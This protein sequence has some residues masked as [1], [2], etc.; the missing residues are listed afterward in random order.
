MTRALLRNLRRGMRVAFFLRVE[1]KVWEA[2][3][4]HVALIA[5][6][7]TVMSI[8]LYWTYYGTS[9]VFDWRGLYGPWLDVV[10]FL[11]VSWL[12]VRYAPRA[13]G[14]L[15][16]AVALFAAAF[17]TG[18]VYVA[19][20]HV[21][22][23]L[24]EWPAVERVAWLGLY[25]GWPVWFGMLAVVLLR[26]TARIAYRHMPVVIAPLVLWM[27]FTY[28]VSAP[29]YWYMPPPDTR[30]TAPPQASPVSEEILYLQP[31]L[32]RQ[33]L[34][35]IADQRA[36]IDDLY[37]IG[38]APHGEEDVFM[39]ESEVIRALMDQRFDTR[40]RSLLLINNNKT[41]LQ[42]PLATATNLQAALKTVGQL[43]DPDDDVL[44][45]YLTS[46][47]TR[48][49]RLS[50]EYWPLRLEQVTPLKLKTW[51]NEAKIRWRIIVVSACF[52]GGYVEP[53][54]GPTTLIM[55]ASD[56]THTS[57][58]CGT[59]SDFTYF[60][61]ALF[62]EQLRETFSFEQAFERAVPVIKE[63]EQVED[64]TFSNPQ[65]AIGEPMRKKLA[66]LERRLEAKARRQQ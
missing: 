42:H 16:I 8:L 50:A 37:F 29:D 7:S 66:R 48:D 61:K 39:K 34:A 5:L 54:R 65:M 56:A 36:G 43:M 47:G 55:T 11:F 15:V 10:V 28:L 51:L 49:H 31:K 45:L 24:T 25:Y 30:S 38:F 46:H 32:T 35:D 1:P 27:A 9:A 2:G 60:A 22:R 18:V 40:G 20:S 58:G 14:P 57:F 53:L 6:F 23:G 4:A 17:V 26:R 64:Q 62:D 13:L 63:R 52:S 21:I 19:L 44:V 3:G 41:L 59:E 33:A 12:A